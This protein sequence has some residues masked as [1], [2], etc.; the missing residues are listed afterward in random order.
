MTAS[1]V[2]HTIAYGTS[3]IGALC[4]HSDEMNNSTDR[5]TESETRMLSELMKIF[6]C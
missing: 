2:S 5:L 6:L 1:H 3:N 4:I